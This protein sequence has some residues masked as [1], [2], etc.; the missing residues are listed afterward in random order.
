MCQGDA[1]YDFCLLFEF[2]GESEP[3]EASEGVL[4]GIVGEELNFLD[5]FEVHHAGLGGY[6]D[7]VQSSNSD[8]DVELRLAGGIAGGDVDRG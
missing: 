3:F 1:F 6:G 2:P 5:F 8:G 7:L 4:I